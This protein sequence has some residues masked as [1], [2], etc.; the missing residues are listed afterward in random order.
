MDVDVANPSTSALSN[1]FQ[2]VVQSLLEA[3]MRSDVKEANLQVSIYEALNIMVQSSAPDVYNLVAAVMPLIMQRLDQTLKQ[4]ADSAEER[5]SVNEIQA[6][7][8]GT[9]QSIVTKL[10]QENIVPHAD[11]LMT[12]FLH[13]LGSKNATVHEEALMAIGAVADKVEQLFVKYMD[14]IKQP[15]FDGLRNAQEHTVCSVAVNV[16]CD[17]TRAVGPQFMPW[18][19]EVMKIL[20]THLQNGAVE[21]TVKPHIISCI[22]DIAIAIGGNFDRYMR[23]VIPMLIAAAGTNYPADDWDNID[24]M[25]QLRESIIEAFSGIL[26]GLSQ[27][28]KVQ[29]FVQEAGLVQAIVALFG[30]IAD[31]GSATER[32]LRNSSGLILDLVRLVGAPIIQTLRVPA[33]EKIIQESMSDGNEPE[34]VRNGKEARKV[35]HTPATW[36]NSQRASERPCRVPSTVYD[37]RLSFEFIHTVFH[38]SRPSRVGLDV[39]DVAENQHATPVSRWGRFCVRALTL[40]CCFFSLQALS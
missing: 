15:L 38:L 2:Q 26:L 21:R 11:A 27:D 12:L 34:T 8:C 33:V 1:Y 20:L 13:V 22:G 30:L 18:G 40:W 16:T 14:H 9:L 3:S 36:A 25:E 5:E 7:L 32:L 10:P 4:R 35:R 23:F 24:Y 31:D 37:E 39:P 29:L 28:S 19:D 17:V 6:L